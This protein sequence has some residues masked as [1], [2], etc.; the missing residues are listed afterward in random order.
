M[1]EKSCNLSTDR[2]GQNEDAHGNSRIQP[3]LRSIQRPRAPCAWRVAFRR[4]KLMELFSREIHPGRLAAHIAVTERYLFAEN[5]QGHASRYTGHGKEFADGREAILKLMERLHAES[6]ESSRSSATRA[7][8][9]CANVGGMEIA[10]WKWMR[11]IVEH[12]IHHRGQV[13]LVP[14]I[15]GVPNASPVWP[16]VGGGARPR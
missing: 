15:L 14:R 10:R 1:A 12:E 16:L 6:M 2:T 3:F 8:R 5:I 13:H 7:S 9:K 4:I 11:S